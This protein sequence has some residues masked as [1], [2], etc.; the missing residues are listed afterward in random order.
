MRKYYLITPQKNAPGADPGVTFITHGCKYLIK[1]ADPDA[2]FLHVSNT[3]HQQADWDLVYHQADCLV[4]AGNPL[5]DTSETRVYWNSGIWEHV[6]KAR[7]LGIPIA[8][9]WGYSAHALPSPALDTMAQAMLS[10]TRTKDLLEIQA[11]FKLVITRDLCAQLVASSM[12][13]DV[14]ALPCCSYWAHRYF[15]IE[16][17]RPTFNAVVLRFMPGQEWILKPLQELSLLLSKEKPTFLICPNNRAYWWAK[18]HLHHPGHLFCI[19]DPAS[20]LDFY[21]RCDKVISIRLHASIPALS[22]GCRVINLS[23]DTRSQTLDLFNIPSV[24]YTALKEPDFPLDFHSLDTS[25]LP[26]P[27]HFLTRFKT[28]IVLGFTHAP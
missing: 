14:D 26:S 1:Q 4:L 9:L 19:Y 10:T 6:D 2:M 15:N 13:E 22:L 11:H 21:S 23:I 20:L 7:A 16:P 8:D 24:P 12:R 3:M 27:D 18:E 28:E 25:H 5:Y 17:K